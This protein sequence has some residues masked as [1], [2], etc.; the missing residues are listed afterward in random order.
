ML[1]LIHIFLLG[2][3]I[4]GLLSLASALRPSVAWLSAI[5]ITAQILLCIAALAAYAAMAL[6]PR[7]P[8]RLLFLPSLFILWRSM[9]SL[10]L[11]LLLPDQHRLLIA[12]IQTA[13][14]AAFL[15]FLRNRRDDPSW[16]GRFTARPSMSLPNLL[17]AALYTP[18]LAATMGGLLTHALLFTIQRETAGYLTLHL[19]GIRSQ[20]RHFQRDDKQ[21]RLVGM[22]HI[23]SPTFY[24]QIRNSVPK[25]SS[26]V[27][28]MEGVTDEKHLLQT[29]FNYARLAKRL[30]LSAQT[31][32]DL[33]A[34]TPSS[35]SRTTS[36]SANPL[37]FRHAD[38]DISTFQP[39]TLALLRAVGRLLSA[40]TLAEALAILRSPELS[41]LNQSRA[42]AM[43]NDILS[44][45]NKHL[46]AEID[47]NL[48]SPHS[49]IV[50]PWGAAHLP[51][52]ESEILKRGFRE[53]QRIT[54]IAIPFAR[55]PEKTGGPEHRP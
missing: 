53:T 40:E 18:L 26:A 5:S 51:G 42:T 16:I 24:E 28:L 27:V 46:L 17:A 15:A 33:H 12:L 13:A 52:I 4:Q 21:V 11:S 22:I 9:G 55:S 1:P 2:W 10:P 14:A 47:Q 44:L 6:S 49:L 8:K 50:V 38:V 35:L 48:D 34:D 30:G 23:A 39:D 25:G 29:S 32:S 37:L 31:D 19:D 45:R 43:M 3:L 36:P 41:D 20:E 54:R 7:P